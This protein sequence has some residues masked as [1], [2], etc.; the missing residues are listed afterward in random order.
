MKIYRWLQSWNPV[1]KVFILSAALAAIVISLSTI[2]IP[3]RIL[4]D[5]LIL[6]AAAVL[7]VFTAAYVSFYNWRKYPAGVAIMLFVVA[8][9]GVFLINALGRWVGVIFNNPDYFGRPALTIAV[10]LFAV[11]ATLWLLVTLLRN[12]SSDVKELPSKRHHSRI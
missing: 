8:L 3:W 12:W 11:F 1:T 4:A 5:V 10:Y 6:V 2:I 9:D 7:I